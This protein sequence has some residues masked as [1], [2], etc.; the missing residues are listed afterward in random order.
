MLWVQAQDMGPSPRNGHGVVCD[1]ARGRLV[2]FGGAAAGKPTGDTWEWD[3]KLWTQVADTGPPARAFHG[4]AYDAAGEQVLVFG[5][6]NADAP[7]SRKYF[8]D[9]WGWDGETWV[10]LADTGPSLRQAPAMAG[11]PTRKRVVLFSGGQTDAQAN[12]LAAADTWE[13]DGSL[14]RQVADTGPSARL[15]ARIAYDF[16]AGQMLLFGGAGSG[17]A[18][19]DTWAWDGARWTQV[20]DTGPLPRVGHAMA[21]LSGGVILF[22]GLP[23]GGGGGALNDTWA[24]TGGDWR[25]TQDMGP[26]ARSGHAMDQVDDVVTLFGGQ[27]AMQDTWRLGQRG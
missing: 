24:W 25:Q 9:T 22:G 6:S 7:D 19:A 12:N 13:W 21:G 4:M 23:L 11:D 15:D 14:W 10:Q 16:G 20:A 3:G 8:G 17:P 27:G 1:P 5:G 2:L 18:T 26:S